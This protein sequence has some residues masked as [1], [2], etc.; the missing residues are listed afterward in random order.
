[1]DEATIDCTFC[2]GAG[3]VE[4]R[5]ERLDDTAEWRRQG[6]WVLCKRHLPDLDSGLWSGLDHAER[7]VVMSL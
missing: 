3:A 7:L 2:G 1:M 4:L 5:L 6:H